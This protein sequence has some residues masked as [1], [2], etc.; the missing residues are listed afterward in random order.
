MH[1][2]SAL[3]SLLLAAFLAGCTLQDVPVGATVEVESVTVVYD[4]APKQPEITVT[5]AG[6]L[7]GATITVTPVGAP[8]GAALPAGTWPVDAGTYQVVVEAGPSVEGGRGEGTL[9][10]APR[11]VTVTPAAGQAK[12]FGDDDP[13][14]V[15]AADGLVGDD[16]L[17]GALAR[18]P[19]EGVG[20]YAFGLGTLDG[21]P[22]YV[23]E[24]AA[25]APVFTIAVG[26]S[27]VEVSDAS[28]TYDGTAHEVA[29]VFDPPEAGVGAVV[30]YG[31]LPAGELPVDVGVYAVS[32][33]VGAGYVGS[34][35][36]TLTIA[37]ASLT[38]TPAADQGK[39][40]G[41]ADPTLAYSASGLFGDD[42]VTGALGRVAGEDVGT[43][44]FTLGTLANPNYALTL[45]DGSPTY[46]IAPRPLVL[47]GFA[48]DGKAY[49]GTTAA[50]GG[51]FEDDRLD[52]DE[53][54]VG[55]VVAFDSA[56]AGPAVS[57]TFSGFE[58]SGPD[59]G[60]YVL[61]TTTGSAT[62][63]IAPRS[64]AVS[65]VLWADKVYDGGTGATASA[66]LVAAGI[67]GDDDVALASQ[68]VGDFASARVG[69]H[70]VTGSF[71]L[72]GTDAANYRIDPQPTGTAAI[73]ARP[74]AL[75]GAVL[76]A[77]T[78]DGS[79]DAVVTGTLQAAT[80][81]DR[82]VLPADAARLGYA[83]SFAQAGA[84]ADPIA[85]TVT[86]TGD[87]ASDYVLDPVPSLS[88]P[89]APATVTVTPD[90]DQGK[91]YGDADPAFGFTT[92]GLLGDDVLSG[93]LARV[94]GED[95]G[96]YAFGLGS[97]D[98]GPDYV[99]ELADDAPTFAIA[100]R[101]I[102][103]TTG[104]PIA[105]YGA[106][107]DATAV[108]ADGSSLRD[109]DALVGALARPALGVGTAD[110][111]LGTAAI[112]RG[113]AD[114]SANYA[115]AFA[116]YEVTAR[117][118]TIVADDR[119]KT[120]GDALDLGTAAFT[121]VA[122]DGDTGLVGDEVVTGVVL[123]SD[124][125]AAAAT[126]VGGPYPV[127]ASDADGAD[128]F[129]PMN[130]AITYLPGDLTVAPRTITLSG[131]FTTATK[132]YDGGT[133]AGAVDASGLVLNGVI[134][135]DDVAIAA[136]AAFADA[137]VAEGKVATLTG[138]STLVG[139]DAGNYALSLDGAPTGVGAVA[140]AD[141]A[142][143]ITIAG[144]DFATEVVYDG[145]RTFQPNVVT[146]LDP[147]PAD[148]PVAYYV[149]ITY[150]RTGAS[151]GS[152]N[153]VGTYTVTVTADDPRYVGS[154]TQAIE[155][156]ARPVTFAS[157]AIGKVFGTL[158]P[159]MVPSLAGGT[160][161]G[162]NDAFLEGGALGYDAGDQA[163]PFAAGTYPVELGSVRIVR[164]LRDVTDQYAITFASDFTIVPATLVVTPATAQGKTYGDAD[165]VFAYTSDGL[166]GDDAL[167]GTLAR[168]EGEDVGAYTFTLG[169]L[170]AGAN[171]DL[172]LAG[173]VP[174]FAIAPRPVTL[175]SAA[176]SY[177]YGDADLD[178]AAVLADG[179]TLRDGDALAGDLALSDANAGTHPFELG[180]ATL[181][182]DG[183]DVLD[184]YAVSFA[185]YAMA[186]R[187]ATV[188]PAADQGKTYGFDD[189][190][191]AYAADLVD[192]DAL[193]GALGRVEGED[194][195]AYA[196]TLGT[197]A[198]PNYALTLADEAPTF[199]ITQRAIALEATVASEAYA[200]DDGDL[201]PALAD[202]SSLRD[203]DVLDGA[204]AHGGVDVGTYPLAIG[205]ARVLRGETDV[206]GNY[207]ITLGD[208]TVVPLPVAFDIVN[209]DLVLGA[210]E[211]RTHVFF[212][213]G[214][215]PIRGL[216]VAVTPDGATPSFRF[217]YRWTHDADHVA[218][219]SP[220][221]VQRIQGLGTYEVTITAT[222]TNHV[223]VSVLT[224]WVTDAV[225]VAFDE[226]A[227]E[228]LVGATVPV[229]LQLVGTD[230]E[231]RAAGPVPL[232]VDVAS[233]APA[234]AAFLADDEPTAATTVTFGPGATFADL[235]VAFVGLG[236]GPATLSA[237][238]TDAGPALDA[239]SAT[240]RATATLVWSPSE[241]SVGAG[242]VSPLATVRLVG[243]EGVA[244]DAPADL[245][246]D[247]TAD[248]AGVVFRDADDTADVTFVTIA[249]GT[250]EADFRVLA[251]EPGA[252]LAAAA[253]DAALAGVGG[254]ALALTV[255][256][257][258]I[259]AS[260]APASVAKAQTV[261]VVLTGSGFAD[262]LAVAF[263]GDDVTVVSVTVDGDT[264]ATVRI[265]LAATTDVGTR[266]VTVTN[267]DGGSATTE[268]ALTLTVPTLTATDDGPF[269]VVEGG[270]RALSIASDLL[271]ND[272][273]TGTT[274]WGFDG[275]VSASGVTY[276]VAGDVLTLTA[277]ADSG[278]SSASLTYRVR[279]AVFGTTAT[280]TVAIDVTLAPVDAIL[281]TDP[282]EFDDFVNTEYS[283]PT[284]AEIFASWPRFNYGTYYADASAWTGT[285]AD[286][287]YYTEDALGDRVVFPQNGSYDGIVSLETFEYYTHEATLYSSNSDDDSIGLIIAFS[288]GAGG[289]RY[290]IAHRTNAGNSPSTGW[291]LSYFDGSYVQTL[292]SA[293]V[294]GFTTYRN[295]TG[296]GWSQSG[297][298]RVKVERAGDLVRLYA[299]NW[300]TT[301]VGTA[302]P[303][304][305]PE[306][307]IVVDLASG[308]I[309]YYDGTGFRTVTSPVALDG[310][311]G[312]Q[313]YGYFVYSQADTSYLNIAF[314]GGAARDTAILLTGYDAE[315]AAYTGSQVWRFTE[316]WA[317][318]VGRT[319]Q[320]ELGFPR[321]VTSVA[322][323]NPGSA[324]PAGYTVHGDRFRIEETTVAPIVD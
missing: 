76:D 165:P 79:T 161:F 14:F 194:V 292:V 139:A 126:V 65:D 251:N 17:T 185:S 302:T 28:V 32:V 188:L 95:V 140:K 247:L 109:G 31:D 73:A 30:T 137:L 199:A 96:G 289:F 130:Y 122:A 169:S 134:D 282:L 254:S 228:G 233:D 48:V 71:Q 100:T 104:T 108:L 36:G 58:L 241:L 279:D 64:L 88:V 238:L 43:Y 127:V 273:W 143:G 106:S 223:G 181:T 280:A 243:H 156:L 149:E 51:T 305:A 304:Y 112:E 146:S 70:G 230:G 278:G 281:F 268:D 42:A 294:P 6:A 321:D 26:A 151:V 232:V 93:A 45:A 128:G 125:A 37:P 8:V 55:F 299:T 322:S 191:L 105:V 40:Y 23:L 101:A 152:F 180:G 133:D 117:P 68:L 262:G 323:P 145:D 204:L 22:N 207:A 257:R 87:A 309:T 226:A 18:E 212:G 290:L 274:A 263:S 86:L 255:N 2:T 319:I 118:L 162:R 131:T 89:I 189:P 220:V 10:I 260:I 166:V 224:V 239:A 25:D 47:S 27:A 136:V 300:F 235:D 229:R 271:A 12:L 208:F 275:V 265:T 267:A 269:G 195:G 171:Y 90:A 312:A 150:D 157:S 4:G 318:D 310:L 29:I 198:N 57:V 197:L 3:L 56:A 160:T 107:F 217:T 120:Y 205:S 91:T 285:T 253:P 248:P 116:A 84:S 94:E 206:S 236:A 49:D 16:A 144:T 142:F 67:V 298:S 320:Q 1:R 306:S 297:A 39:T 103:L 114:V 283:V 34:A 21:G 9:I 215:E 119:A 295:G 184:N 175:T 225:G 266:D 178:L 315:L 154:S 252:Y 324:Y 78:F 7:V 81:F 124:G 163:E 5:P 216:E 173:E 141:I 50:A 221:T 222:S 316:G 244:V 303:A 44:A 277:P 41:Q 35:S 129:D 60:N 82:G 210:A 99:L 259:V 291:G 59:A 261:D 15:F 155:V 61:A 110:F 270:N 38:V 179:G 135:G 276:G 314:E 287:W 111:A 296:S 196:F 190:V 177:V 20:T 121:V 245:R 115:I 164:G 192:G 138:A 172:V 213:D 69:T 174:T 98:G 231:P 33:Q 237:T 170:D 240:V 187:P 246:I 148:Q 77:K 227:Y 183:V 272:G 132:P 249:A 313:R 256:P 242:A 113:E 219:A 258:P 158:D 193:T 159:L 63:A 75:L 153:P 202:G 123:A 284:F 147:I 311:R 83:A 201:R 317:L 46:A 203:G 11:P 19:G 53:L 72:V 211:T 54:T 62:A 167:T 264:Q 307:E 52:G 186:A 176:P 200:T 13:D 293:S 286:L 24:L 80:G 97:L 102:T 66:T 209:P 74:V 301:D 218:F 214:A 85:V 168:V 182:R 92:S 308:A 288:G 234:V 250:S